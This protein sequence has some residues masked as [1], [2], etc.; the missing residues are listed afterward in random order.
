M[1]CFC[2]AITIGYSALV[3][4][5]TVDKNGLVHVSFVM[6]K[7]KVAHLKLV[8]I[9]RQELVAA[10]IGINIVQLI[11]LKTD[12]SISRVLYWT[13]S[14]SV[15]KYIFNKTR[16]FYVSVANKI[17]RIY[18]ASNSSQWRYVETKLNQ[19]NLKSQ[20]L[21][22]NQIKTAELSFDGPTFLKEDKNCWPRPPEDCFQISNS[23][24]EVKY[25][26]PTKVCL[27]TNVDTKGSMQHTL[28]L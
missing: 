27:T 3:Y 11:Q 9:P 26:R 28:Q 24:Q 8:S 25:T 13:N 1:H 14:T 15:L 22:P 17:F 19:I 6:G 10:V 12:L 5:R 21:L 16:R 18:E 23:N 7:S 2:D 4:L 20:G